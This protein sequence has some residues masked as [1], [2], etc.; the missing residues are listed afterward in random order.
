MAMSF[1]I[2]TA[3][4]TGLEK[5]AYMESHLDEFPHTT[6]NGAWLT[7]KTGHW[8]GGFWIG[9]LWLKSLHSSNATED[10]AEALRWAMQLRA[11]K[12]DNKTHDQVF[13]FGPSCVLGNRIFGATELVEMALCGAHNM[14]DL[15]KEKS[16]LILAWDEPNYEGVAI[17]DTI[18]NLPLLLWAAEHEENPVF[19]GVAATVASNIAK[20]HVR[21]DYSTIHKVRWDTN[22]YEVVEKST[23]QGYSPDSCWSRGQAWALYGYANMYR[24]TGDSCYINM[25]AG[26]AE[27]FWTHLDDEVALPRWDFHFKNHTDQP[28]D[29]SA[30][31]IAAA[32]M[33]LLAEMLRRRGDLSGFDLWVK[34]GKYLLASLY[35]NC[36]Y[37]DITKFGILEKATVDKPHN[38]G[39][40]ESTM[41]GD[42]YFMEALYRL[43]NVNTP[44]SLDLLY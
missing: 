27:Y 42:Y 6:K 5:V 9:L 13:I 21:P 2:Q 11:R 38:S 36:R 31:S 32:G 19:K 30:A 1:D 12:T 23:H 16:G 3:L 43:L 25:S 18:M 33:L 44:K 14:I 39:I 34:R 24:Y 15:Y 7:H 20:H 26:L 22:S 40:G 8:T 37:S 41:Y 28:F 35:T 4:R 17:V 29:S 10:Q